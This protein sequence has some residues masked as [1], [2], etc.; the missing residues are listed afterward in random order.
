[1]TPLS[2]AAPGRRSVMLRRGMVTVGEGAARARS[3]PQER[4]NEEWL[5]A[6]QDPGPAGAAALGDLR[7]HLLAGLQGALARRGAGADACEDFAQE[8]LVR[9]QAQIGGFRGESRFTTWA[10]SIAVRV[11][12]DELRRKRWKD[13]PFDAVTEDARAPIDLAAPGSGAPQE[14]DLVRERVL[15][16]LRAVIDGA[17]TDRQRQVLVAEL[18]GMPHDEIARRIGTNRNALYKLSHDARRKIKAHLAAAG[19]SEAD[20]LWAFE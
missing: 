17:L 12:F 14:R 6:L 16:A 3:S 15:S 8:A 13:V 11:A 5:R 20:V 2:L 18:A 7:A 10:L 19:I 4:S 9:I 1:M